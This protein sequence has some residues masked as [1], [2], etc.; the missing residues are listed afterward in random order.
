MTILRLKKGVRLLGLQPQTVFGIMVAHSCYSAVNKDG[1]CFI[2]SGTEGR[3]SRGSRHYVGLAFDLRMRRLTKEQKK[4]LHGM[5]KEA[6]TNQFD[7]VLE[8]T[9]IHVEYDPE[10]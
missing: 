8:K 7:V 9:H 10:R 5:I 4:I 1:E 6:L 2:T 3:H